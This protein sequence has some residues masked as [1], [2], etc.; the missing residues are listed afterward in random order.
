MALRVVGELRLPEG[1]GPRHAVISE[2]D[3]FLYVLTELTHAV[4]TFKLPEG[5]DASSWSSPLHPLDTKGSEIVPP[6]VPS[7]LRP[8]MTA[9]ELLRSPT[10]GS[11][12][13]YASNRGQV[14]LGAGGGG[15]QGDA[16]A[17]ITL[18]D[19]GASVANVDIIQTSVNFIRGMGISPDGKYLVLVGQKDGKVAL[20]ETGGERGEKLELVTG[21]EGGKSGL[22]APT[23]VT[24]V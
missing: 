1:S 23:D 19:D 12:T 24:F 22:E 15:V 17:V 4:Y 7:D 10:H 9:G 3:K 2:D 16:L 20:Y 14:D 21:L 18:A 5:T 11:K 8:Q 6:A 13:L